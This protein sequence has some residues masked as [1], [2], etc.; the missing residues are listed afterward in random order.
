VV[1]VIRFVAAAK[2]RRT[3]FQTP[4]PREP[5]YQHTKFDILQRPYVG[6]TKPKSV[7]IRLDHDGT[8]ENLEFRNYLGFGSNC[9]YNDRSFFIVAAE[10]KLRVRSSSGL[11]IRKEN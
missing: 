1:Y 7:K 2:W 3:S 6:R 8:R 9:I 5:V 11:R 4:L 10:H